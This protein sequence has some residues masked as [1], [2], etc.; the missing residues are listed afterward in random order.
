MR[1]YGLERLA[2]AGEEETV[3]TRHRDAFLA[4][5][6]D[7]GS[8]LESGR[9]IEGLELL[10]PEAGNLAAAL[11][12]AIGTEPAIALR[13]CS[14]VHRWW[15]IRGRYLEAELA[16]ARSLEAGS[17]ADPALRA[18]A[19]EARAYVKVWTAEFDAA[20]ADATEALSLVGTDDPSTSA[21]ARCDLAIATLYGDPRSGRAEATR[22]AELASR[23][24]RPVGSRD[25]EAADRQH[26]LLRVESPG[27][28][29]KPARGR[30]PRR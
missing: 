20:A 12:F 26:P 24:G 25:R 28:D 7:V 19:Y 4:F 21:R 16:L 22:A 11:E 10:D 17:A 2:D 1:D 27:G 18:R 23:S 29:A 3:R 13:L 6:E 9:Q 5:A 15:A 30:R 14:A 8:L